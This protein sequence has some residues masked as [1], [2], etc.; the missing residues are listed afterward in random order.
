MKNA[1]DRLISKL[2]M[3]EEKISESKDSQQTLLKLK[4]KRKRW[5]LQNRISKN[6]ENNYKRYN[7]HVIYVM[8]KP[9]VR[10]GTEQYLKQQ[11]SPNSCQTPNHKS[12]KLRKHRAGKTL[13]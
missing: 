2:D 11:Y 10:E 1:F 13:K 9:K 4:A 3:A 7:I 8:A 6:Y 12:R 5:K